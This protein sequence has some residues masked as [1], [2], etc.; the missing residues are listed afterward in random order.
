MFDPT[1]SERKE[2]MS[3]SALFVGFSAPVRGREQ[4]AVGVFGEAMA[5]YAQLQ[6]DGMIE[7]YEP[8]FLEP[9]GGDLG[10]FF[11]LRG[12]DDK[13]GQVRMSDDFER[14]NIRASLVVEDFG[15]IGA[16]TGA[17]VER[18]MTLYQAQ[19]QDLASPAPAA[20]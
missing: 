12:D 6:S 2:A 1:G 15:V 16:I 13:L 11:L 14:L 5:L 17:G 19:L 7:S 10:G 8:I 9:H 3:E 4:Q 20:A 18:Q